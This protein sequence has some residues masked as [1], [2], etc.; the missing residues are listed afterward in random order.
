[1]ILKETPQSKNAKTPPSI[2]P[3]PSQL[4]VSLCYLESSDEP[5]R[6]RRNASPGLRRRSGG[7]VKEGEG[8]NWDLFVRTDVLLTSTILYGRPYL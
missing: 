8:Y 2:Y 5:V 3:I 7:V 1:M 4:C 6:L